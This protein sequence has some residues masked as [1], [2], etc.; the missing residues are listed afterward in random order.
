MSINEQ[1]TDF[2]NNQLLVVS[3]NLE[4]VRSLTDTITVYIDNTTPDNRTAYSAVC[5]LSLIIKNTE[6]LLDNAIDD[7]CK[8]ANVK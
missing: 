4:Q 8:I 2:C 5:G 1:V 6:Q 7:L 3:N